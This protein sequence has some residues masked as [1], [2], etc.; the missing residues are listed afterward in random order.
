MKVILTGELRG[1]GGEGDVI[2]V[3]DGFANNWLYPQKLA[4]PATSGNL[5]QLEQRRKNIQKREADRLS[6]AG[7]LK[8]QLDGKVVRI[9]SKVGDEGQLFGSVTSSMVADAAKEQLGIEIDRKRV[10]L[11]QPIK[12]SGT[13][14]VDVS[15]YR[16]V[17]ATI[18]VEVNDAAG[19]AAADAKAKEAQAAEAEADATEQEAP[20]AAE[21]AE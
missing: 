11:N 18:L 6:G 15:L 9:E 4:I 8:E 19:F 16:E 20:E 5:R 21:D 1:K 12:T 7:S 10:V 3:A 14:S 13:H 17:M 2:D